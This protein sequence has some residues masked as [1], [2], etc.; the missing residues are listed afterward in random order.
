MLQVARRTMSSALDQLKQFTTVVADTGDIKSESV[1]LVFNYKSDISP[2]TRLPAIAQ[3]K[4]TDATT[5]PSLLYAAAQ[6]SD[7]QKL[8]DD[9]IT[10]AKA[11]PG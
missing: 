9:A 8:V 10:F 5:N 2:S 3:Y 4:P 11:Q 6:I 7:Y 1:L